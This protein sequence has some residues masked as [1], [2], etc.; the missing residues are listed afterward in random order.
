MFR[1]SGRKKHLEPHTAFEIEVGMNG[2]CGELVRWG[3]QDG[4]ASRS[5]QLEKF[6]PLLL[7]LV[8][9]ADLVELGGVARDSRFQPLDG[10]VGEEP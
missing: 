6:I 2:A 1:T 7:K 3:V 10:V 5:E 8:R 4:C 9:H